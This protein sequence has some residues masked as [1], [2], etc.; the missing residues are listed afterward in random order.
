MNYTALPTC[1]K[2]A[3]CTVTLWGEMVL[4]TQEPLSHNSHFLILSFIVVI[5]KGTFLSLSSPLPSPCA[6]LL[7]NVSSPSLLLP[8][9]ICLPLSCSAAL[10]SGT[11]HHCLW[12][13]SAPFGAAGFVPLAIA[14][15]I[16]KWQFIRHWATFPTEWTSRPLRPKFQNTKHHPP[17]QLYVE[18]TCITASM[19]W[20]FA[21]GVSPPFFF[22]ESGK[23]AVYLH[24][25]S[26]PGLE[27]AGQSS[28]ATPPGTLMQLGADPALLASRSWSALCVQPCGPSQICV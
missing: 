5:K 2:A 21:A 1:Q 14:K 11:F 26:V 18:M 16:P 9:L 25:V 27:A 17:P 23:S 6:Q 4:V 19:F 3:A 10:C 8:L 24:L 7:C 13:C 12:R 20:D 22:E 15:G 28:F